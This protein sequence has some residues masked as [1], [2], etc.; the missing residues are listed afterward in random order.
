MI[1]VSN[2]KISSQKYKGKNKKKLINA[3]L[4]KKSIG[5]NVKQRKK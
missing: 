1:E 4:I 2:K 5:K 3:P